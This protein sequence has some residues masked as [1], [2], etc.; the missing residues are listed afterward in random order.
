M[1]KKIDSS[2]SKI[3]NEEEKGVV[4][5]NFGNDDIVIMTGKRG[6]AF[7]DYDASCPS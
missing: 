4:R 5:H 2:Q 3:S 1:E 6:H 7:A